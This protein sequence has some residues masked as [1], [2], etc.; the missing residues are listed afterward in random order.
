MKD[1]LIESYYIQWERTRNRTVQMIK[2]ASDEL[3][4]YTPEKQY[5]YIR[6]VLHIMEWEIEM[7]QRAG[8]NYNHQL[9]ETEVKSK[10]QLLDY[11]LKVTK[12]TK[13][14]MDELGDNILDLT[15]PIDNIDT[16]FYEVLLD[17]ID[18]ESHHRGQI[19]SYY[20]YF[21]MTPPHYE[22]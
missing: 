6:Q 2:Y 15:I 7:F 18:H 1:K 3:F 13:S 21:N 20:R 11:T 4:K 12:T 19:V 8:F 10:H 17:L 16:P 14:Y 22:I 5:S 9:D